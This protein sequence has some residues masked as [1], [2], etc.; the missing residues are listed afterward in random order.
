VLLHFTTT[1]KP[2][3]PL[4]PKNAGIK[5]INNYIWTM[6]YKKTLFCVNLLMTSYQNAEAKKKKCEEVRKTA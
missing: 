2:L 1:T 5:F 3:T 4:P 6:Y